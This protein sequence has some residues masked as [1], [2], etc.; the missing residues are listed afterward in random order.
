MAKVTLISTGGT[1]EKIYDESNGEMKNCGPQIEKN[2]S[3]ALRLPYCDL[4]F[5]SL[6]SKDSLFMD[7]QDR[8]KILECL[9]SYEKTGNPIIVLHGTDTMEHTAQ[10]CAQLMENPEVPIVFTGSMKPYGFQDSDAMQN[11]CEA[12]L[13]AKFLSAGL[14]VVFH[15]HIFDA[16]KVTKNR[17]RMTFET[18]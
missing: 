16:T 17:D 9:K 3:D 12:L 8:H 5:V 1:I 18:V 4:E 6:M 15:N 11:V 2:L 7:D 10:Y 14:Y 13:A